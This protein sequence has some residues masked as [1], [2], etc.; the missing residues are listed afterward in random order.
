MHA[1]ELDLL[2]RRVGLGAGRRRIDAL[3]QGMGVG[4][5]HEGGEDLAGQGHIIGE[6][7][8]AAQQPEILETRKGPP[9]PWSAIASGFLSPTHRMFAAHLAS[10]LLHLRLW[11]V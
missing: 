8:C 1:G 6:T 2:Q 5:A 10:P 3:D 11:A 9:D 7:A 4:R